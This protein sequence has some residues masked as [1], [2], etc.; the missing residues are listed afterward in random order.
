MSKFQ[1]GKI[2]ATRAALEAIDASGQVPSFFFHRHIQGDWGCVQ[3][4]DK[5][6]NDQAL[7]DGLVLLPLTARSRASGCGSSRKPPMT[8]A[9]VHRPR[10]CCQR[11]IVLPADC[12]LKGGS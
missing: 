4:N 3:D 10:F 8:T 6:A 2:F 12:T 1:L 5:R 7:V 9:T 11:S